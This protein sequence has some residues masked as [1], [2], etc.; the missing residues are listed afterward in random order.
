MNI[1]SEVKKGEK[2]TVDIIAEI[3]VTDFE[4][5]REAALAELG[6]N[7]EIKGFRKG[8]APAEMIEKQ[9]GDMRILD[10]MAHHAIS[11]SYTQLLTE[12]KIDAIGRPMV[13]IT[14]MAKGNPLGFT[15]TTA[16]MPVVELPDYKKIAKKE[17]EKKGEGKIT[18]KELDDAIMQIQKMRAQDDAIR[19]GV[20][21]KEAKEAPVKDLDDE[22]VQSL[23]AFENVADFKNKL[24]ENLELEKENKEREKKQLAIADALIEKSTIDVPELLV[25]HELQKMMAQ[26]EH[27]IS[28]T[29]M[30]FDDYLKHI[31]KSKDDLKKEWYETAEK[32][33]KMSLIIEK[34]AEE[35]NLHPS[36]EEVSTEAS[37]IMTQYKD[38]KDIDEN[39]VRAYVNS[40]L[41][42]QKVFNFFEEQGK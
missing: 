29:G 22:Y 32:R 30:K 7:V 10:E 24:R 38:M 4:S 3:N 18:D 25:E 41:M 34:V 33:S 8:A 9:L 37:K 19:D 16:V 21:P 11:A 28:M 12:H 6:K 2:S 40:I 39:S 35:E 36:E 14:K 42:N 15:I 13:N 26:M 1:T 5:Y 31:Q 27:D 23:G 20:E 17:M